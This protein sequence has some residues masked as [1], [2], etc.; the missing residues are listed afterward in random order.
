MENQYQK[1]YSVSEINNY[2][3]NIIENSFEEYIIVE[4]EISQMNVAQSGHIYITLKDKHSTVRC[5]LWSAR[6]Q[7]MDIYPE[8]WIKSYYKLQSFILRKKWFISIRYY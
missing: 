5:T 1:I 7:K 6:V 4:G 8:D 2:V 3:K